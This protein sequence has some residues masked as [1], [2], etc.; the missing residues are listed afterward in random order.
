MSEMINCDINIIDREI[1][2][3]S[4][5]EIGIPRNKIEIFEIDNAGEIIGYG[6]RRAK[7]H[8]IVRRNTL[9]T[10]YG[11]VGFEFIV[12]NNKITGC[13]IH[14]D[15]ADAHH[16]ICNKI[17]P[18]KIHGSG[19]LAKIYAKNSILK[20]IKRRGAFRLLSNTKD[21]DKIKIKVSVQ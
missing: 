10:S 16:G 1:L 15:H 21:K 7:A 13:K 3:E 9:G 8:V 18:T 20:E 5:E 11:D 14:L 2:I 4:L 6:S 19:E 12:E 17:A